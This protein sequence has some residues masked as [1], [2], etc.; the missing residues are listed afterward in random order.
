MQFISEFERNYIVILRACKKKWSSGGG[1][2]AF[3]QFARDIC[4]F[5]EFASLKVLGIPPSG[6][7]V[8]SF[9]AGII[10][11][12]GASSFDELLIPTPGL[13]VGPFDAGRSC[14]RWGL[15]PSGL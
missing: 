5:V 1:L 15:L 11:S 9:E 14:F 8:I 10:F 13:R 12:D 4:H 7:L 3:G 2:R 6:P